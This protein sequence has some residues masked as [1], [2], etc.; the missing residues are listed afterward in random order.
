MADTS[1]IVPF[2]GPDMPFRGDDWLGF[3]TYLYVG[4]IAQGY[5]AAPSTAET[6][7]QSRTFW[8]PIDPNNHAICL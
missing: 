2:A 1:H 3:L 4:M 5:Y 7:V 6:R 8:L